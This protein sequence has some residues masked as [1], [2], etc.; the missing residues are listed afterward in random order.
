MRIENRKAYFN[1]HIEEKV[2][3]GMVLKGN[4]IKSIRKGMCNLKESWVSI[5]NGEMYA[6][7][8]HITPWETANRYDLHLGEPIKLLAKKKEI[9]D[10][11]KKIEQEGYTLVPLSIYFVK[12][13][14]K[15]EIGL[16]KGKK[17]Y[18]KRETLKQKDTQREID[19][20]VKNMYY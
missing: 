5:E 10:L 19:R 11:Q 9:L 1:Y 2:E 16:C 3:C 18:D 8:V 7:Q 12:Q 20:A 15:M 13:Y 6:K 14:C 4:Q 17:L